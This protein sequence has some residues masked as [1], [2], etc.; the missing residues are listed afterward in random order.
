MGGPGSGWEGKRHKFMKV[1]TPLIC[2]L[3]KIQQV[4]CKCIVNRVAKEW[5]M[6]G[7]FP[8]TFH[9]KLS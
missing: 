5:K 1:S 8:G 3:K 6:S 7:N 2:C 4:N 9:G